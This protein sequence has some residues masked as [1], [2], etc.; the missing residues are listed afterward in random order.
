M[1]ACVWFG[2][3]WEKCTWLRGG[4]CPLG[5]FLGQ[6]CGP[7]SKFSERFGVLG[8]KGQ[9]GTTGDVGLGDG[10]LGHELFEAV[11]SGEWLVLE[12]GR[13]EVAEEFSPFIQD[14]EVLSNEGFGLGIVVERGCGFDQA[15]VADLPHVA[16]S[17]WVINDFLGLRF[18]IGLSPV[19]QRGPDVDPQRHDEHR[20]DE[21]HDTLARGVSGKVRV[22]GLVR[23]P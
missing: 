5:P 8:R 21:E 12:L 20:T 22:V 23:L 19:S 6:C 3:P 14:G 13:A 11:A 15:R 4:R 17:A 10:H 16:H 7:L 1:M 18:P 9:G 2:S